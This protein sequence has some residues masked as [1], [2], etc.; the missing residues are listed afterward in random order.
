MNIDSEPVRMRMVRVEEPRG[1]LRFEFSVPDSW[2]ARQVGPDEFEL[3][4]KVGP[5]VLF[6]RF[7]DCGVWQAR[8]RP[9]GEGG[10]SDLAQFASDWRLIRLPSDELRVVRRNVSVVGAD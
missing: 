6:G 2:K 8:P 4:P 10:G 5:P 9:R 3:G 1:Q 7:E